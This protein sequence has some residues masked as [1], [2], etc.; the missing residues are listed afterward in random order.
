MKKL[1]E[2][3][4]LKLEFSNHTQNISALKGIDFSLFENEI[5]GFVGESGCGK[6]VL[7]RSILK[8]LDKN[9]TIT[10]GEIFFEEENL[11]KK[12][13]KE[14]RKVRG[15]KIAIIFQDPFSSLNPTMKIGKQILEAIK[16]ER[17]KEK[18]F[19]LLK[20]VQISD[21]EIRYNQYPHE[22]SGGLRQRVMIAIAIASNPKILIADE[23]TTSLDATIKY[24]II[25]LL[26]SLHKKYGTSIIFISH[27]LSLVTNIASK[28]F[29]MKDGKIIERLTS[30]NIFKEAK[31]P[32][33]KML[34]SFCLS[35]DPEK[36]SQKDKTALKKIW[37][38]SIVDK[39]IKPVLSKGKNGK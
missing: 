1:L 10:D 31:H 23:A 36:E 13:E 4:N 16:T 15:E 34:L 17:S 18:V 19:N 22:L 29:V 7:C 25:E 39:K 30:E 5:L 24:E 2:V 6:S 28:I 3:K 21:P 35:L 11:L 8:L 37:K 14:M 27:D 33:T 32:Y 9:A 26:K 20:D 12:S 38:K